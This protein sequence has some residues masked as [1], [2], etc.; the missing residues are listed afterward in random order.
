MTKILS[1]EPQYILKEGKPTAVILSIHDYEEL[2]EKIEDT[3][4]LEELKRIKKRKLKFRP[5]EEFL[6]KNV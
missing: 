5:F 6:K 3:H 4:D 1:Q 2:L